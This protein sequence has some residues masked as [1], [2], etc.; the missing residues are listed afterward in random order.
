LCIQLKR[1]D[2]DW[3]SNRSLKFDDYFEFPR[4]LDVSPYMY[5]SINKVRVATSISEESEDSALNSDQMETDNSV[6][7]DVIYDLVGIVVH[8]GQANAGH[9]YSFIKGNVINQ[10]S[11]DQ[12]LNELKELNRLQDDNQDQS[13]Q[14]FSNEKWYKFND[15]TV[16]EIN[17]NES[18][19]IEECF[20]GTFTQSS[21]YKMLPEERVRYWNG[22]ML[23]YRVSDYN[24]TS[25]Q[26][27]LRMANNK[28]KLQQQS[29]SFS[30]KS[31]STNDSLSELTEL[32][33]KGDE[34]GLFRTHLPPSIEQAVKAEN[35]DFCKNRA[36][37]EQDYF[38]FIY[39]LVKNCQEK[40]FMTERA[41]IVTECCK[42]GLEFL[43]NTFFKTGKKLRVD[44]YK[45]LDLFKDIS[46]NSREGSETILNFTVNHEEN[47]GFIRHYLLECPII[48]IREACAQI[49]ECSLSSLITKHKCN[50]I[51][52]LKITSFITSCVQ[53]LDKAVIDLSKNSHEYFKM[54]Y[55]YADL[56][57][58]STQHLI[59]LSLFNK[60][61]CFLL[62]NPSTKSDET[63]SRRWTTNQSR[64]FAIVHEL[65]SLIVL[66][67][68]ILSMKTCDLPERPMQIITDSL[69]E[70][71]SKVSAAKEL[72]F[73]ESS[74]QASSQIQLESILQKSLTPCPPA[75]QPPIDTSHLITLPQEMQIYLIG[76]LSNRYLKELVFSFEQINHNQLTK[77]LEMVLTCCYCNEAFSANLIHQILIH[78]NNSN[79]NEIKQVL[80]L[81]HNIILI[82]DPLQLKRL[83]LAIDGY[84]DNHVVY[85]G[86]LSIV[87]Q[88]QSSDAKK[89]YQCVKFIVTLAN[90]SGSCKDY[91]LKTANNWEWSVN[92]LKTKMLE[93]LGSSSQFNT[94]WTS[95][96]F[97]NEDSE[98]RTF[99][100]T[101]SAQ[102]TLDDATALLRSSEFD[103]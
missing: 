92:W 32:V 6:K 3:E 30:N 38:R 52:D 26:S 22:Y 73:S 68:N 18:M 42:L 98:V 33:T 84:K 43:F 94:N 27:V 70:L 31:R 77:T 82:E 35:L 89:S 62:G 51:D 93:S 29:L 37:Y 23:F 39:Y 101:K 90:R 25:Q 69:T 19:L 57:K 12:E 102:R 36:I 13:V 28:L 41:L 58:E 54:L 59:S 97:S 1:F 11:Q 61:L 76:A 100:R 95:N 45:W 87:R 86:L 53:L 103:L 85:N 5:E 24:A 71:P 79:F 48:E 49:F 47:S 78:I 88:N 20:G 34:K 46:Y 40:E 66:K 99:Q 67:C 4:K 91:L 8:S 10:N 7:K 60:L 63:T 56:S 9:Y 44:L 65:I 96:K 81:L 72:D 75:F 50:P 55:T 64:E 17:L 80:I 14:E 15:T 21:E 83:R 2:Y 74:P 16:E